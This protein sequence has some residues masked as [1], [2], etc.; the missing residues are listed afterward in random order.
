MNSA[1]LRRAPRNHP[2]KTGKCLALEIRV[3]RPAPPPLP[4]L[5]PRASLQ[6]R[7]LL[8][9]PPP[10]QSGPCFNTAP[11]SRLRRSSFPPFSRGIVAET[12][13]S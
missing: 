9:F 11:T 12:P 4:L 10:F 2:E 6:F 1:E 8:P 5:L 13:I 3:P 7:P